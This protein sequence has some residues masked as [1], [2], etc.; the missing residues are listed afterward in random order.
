MYVCTTSVKINTYLDVVRARGLQKLVQGLVDV[1]Y[2]VPTHLV[3]ALAA[4][5]YPIEKIKANAEYLQG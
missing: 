1:S 2:G 4:L 3:H 5:R